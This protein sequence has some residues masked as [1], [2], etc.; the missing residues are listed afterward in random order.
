MKQK[1]EQNS[2][3]CKRARPISLLKL[4]WLFYR[5]L[6]WNNVVSQNDP[7]C[8]VVSQNDACN[9]PRCE[10]MHWYHFH[11]NIHSNPAIYSKPLRFR[12][13]LSVTVS[14][15]K[16]NVLFGKVMW[17]WGSCN[18]KIY[19]FTYSNPSRVGICS[20]SLDLLWFLTKQLIYVLNVM[21][22]SGSCDLKLHSVGLLQSKLCSLTMVDHEFNGFRWY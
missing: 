5:K 4:L 20:V 19:N 13:A 16:A 2:V 15:I 7:R 6:I 11:L 9:I 14:E 18:H 1:N 12:F 10:I 8:N 3:K 22:P 17:L 21:W